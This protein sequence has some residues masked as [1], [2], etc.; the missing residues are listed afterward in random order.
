MAVH[1]AQ[2]AVAARL[3][4]QMELTR[5]LRI[6]RDNVYQLFRNILRMAGHKADGKI[7]VYLAD[8]LEQV[9]ESISVAVYSVAAV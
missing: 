1:L 9:G 8:I 4:R 2:N 3:Q 7:A 6:I 5:Y